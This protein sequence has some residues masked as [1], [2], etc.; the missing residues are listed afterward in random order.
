MM[1]GVSWNYCDQCS[2]WTT[3]ANEHRTTTNI[4][5]AVPL[6][7]PWG[8]NPPAA[9]TEAPA[10]PAGILVQ[11][12]P[13]N[14]TDGGVNLKGSMP[15]ELVGDPD[16]GGNSIYDGGYLSLMGHLLIGGSFTSDSNP[17]TSYDVDVGAPYF[18]SDRLFFRDE[19]CDKIEA[20][21]FYDAVK[22]LHKNGTLAT[23]TKV[24]TPGDELPP[25]D[26]PGDQDFDAYDYEDAPE[27]PDHA[28]PGK[29]CQCGAY[30]WVER[31]FTHCNGLYELVDQADVYKD[32]VEEYP[33]DRGLDL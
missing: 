31:D 18:C 28:A 29:C 3:G 24:T 32:S 14:N 26:H 33:G 16:I 2:L 19:F 25:S 10:P 27:P 5:R 20:D 7:N 4:C 17:T 8:S 13:T 21:T 23:D 22:N 9:P 1:E 6:E 30:G 15:V 12:V 11:A